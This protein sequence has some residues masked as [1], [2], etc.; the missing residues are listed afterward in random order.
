MRLS[1]HPVSI[2]GLAGVIVVCLGLVLAIGLSALAEQSE[3]V[4]SEIKVWTIG[5]H[6]S[7]SASRQLAAGTD[8]GEGIY[9]SINEGISF[10]GDGTGIELNRVSS[11]STSN[12][13]QYAGTWGGG[14][15]ERPIGSEAW[16]L[17]DALVSGF[18]YIYSMAVSPHGDVVGAD[19]DR[20][21]Y[22]FP[23]SRDQWHTVSP[24]SL[25]AGTLL[26][27]YFS[28]DGT[29]YAGLTRS[30]G[31]Y[32]YRASPEDPYH[33]YWELEGNTH[34]DLEIHDIVEGPGGMLWL[35][36][37]LGPYYWENDNWV[38]WSRG[39]APG[40]ITSL[41]ANPYRAQEELF[42]GTLSGEVWRYRSSSDLW[43][44][45]QGF[46]IPANTR[47]RGFGFS[48]I[49]RLL[50]AT[51]KGL[52]KA[53]GVALRPP[54]TATPTA[55][56]TPTAT[57]MPTFTPGPLPT[58]TMPPTLPPGERTL[59]PLVLRSVAMPLAD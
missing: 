13:F 35:G 26:C 51:D 29:L 32:V 14:V 43:E 6:P 53:D 3:G 44:K 30:R 16:T 20:Y 8:G 59:L 1:K 11:L 41:R 15:Y 48:S 38:K 2:L 31:P 49:G 9:S 28:S 52:Y 17:S 25:P 7:E 34:E 5:E 56:M 23:A 19:P 40:I 57:P 21:I 46:G 54:A 10:V 33:G 58:A 42:A 47:V 24:E 45:I 4:P 50:V 18:N 22:W 27:L 36:T 55:T 37:T 39:A 12:G